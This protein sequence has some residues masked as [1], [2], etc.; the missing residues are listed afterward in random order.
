MLQL[1]RISELEAS[2]NFEAA[3]SEY[4]TLISQ[5]PLN[6]YL[7]YRYVTLLEKSMIVTKKQ[8]GSSAKIAQK[9]PARS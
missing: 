6:L 3:S 1:M 9:H 4:A 7:Q 5:Q 2:K 8:P